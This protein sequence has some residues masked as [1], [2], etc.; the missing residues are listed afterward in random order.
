MMANNDA[1]SRLTDTLR[2]ATGALSAWQRTLRN[3]NVP[4]AR[5]A[6]AFNAPGPLFRPSEP[7]RFLREQNVTTGG[8]ITPST[9]EVPPENVRPITNVTLEIDGKKLAE[10]MDVEQGRMS[11]RGR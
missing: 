5:F 6:A 3:P 2:A 1:Q 8:F 10:I 11:A 9:P 4:T 7:T